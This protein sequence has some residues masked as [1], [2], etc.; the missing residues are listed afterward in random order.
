[1]I[2]DGY[3][4]VGSRNGTFREVGRWSGMWGEEKELENRDVIYVGDTYFRFEVHNN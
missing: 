2:S 3:N 1:M 4:G